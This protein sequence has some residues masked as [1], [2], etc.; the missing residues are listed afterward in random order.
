MEDA[1]KSGVTAAMLRDENPPEESDIA[2]TVEVPQIARPPGDETTAYDQPDDKTAALASSLVAT[3]FEKAKETIATSPKKTILSMSSVVKQRLS[4]TKQR[5]KPKKSPGNKTRK[6]LGVNLIDGV[7]DGGGYLQLPMSRMSV[8]WSTASTRDEESVPTSPTELD[9]IALG[10]VNSVEEYSS[11]LAD[12][13]IKEVITNVSAPQQ[14]LF[15]Q[16]ADENVLSFRVQTF[17]HSLE[18]IS[19]FSSDLE[20]ATIPPFSPHCYNLRKSLLRSVATGHRSQ[21]GDPQLQAII[22]WMAVS[23]CG[24]PEMRYSTFNEE[25]LQQVY[26]GPCLHTSAHQSYRI[27]TS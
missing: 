3:A 17:L 8:A 4:P 11:L 21:G 23:M 14:L 13:I 12:L 26:S 9:H 15:S 25:N 7:R 27:V 1:I 19:P 2:I 10:M 22:H 24:R 18:E 6:H 16:C 5:K 20:T